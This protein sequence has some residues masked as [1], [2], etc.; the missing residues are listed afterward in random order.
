MSVENDLKLLLGALS[1]SAHKHRD[2]RRK[3]V[4]ASPY[5][6]HPI[7]VA[8]VLC[9]EGDVA[10]VAVICAALLHD[11]IEDTETLRDELVQE[12]GASITAIVEEVTDDKT[13]DKDVRKRLQI[14]HAV[15]ASRQAK[16]VKLAD[17]ICN[18]RDISSSPPAGWGTHRKQ[19]YFD[20]ANEVINEV[21]GVHPGLEA[22]FDIEYRKKPSSAAS[23][24]TA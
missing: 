22:L 16:L 17:K 19:A 13:L 12:F 21:R 3:D 18:L 9:N 6:N 5:I 14:E 4:D 11:T 10:E 7:S 1:F 8:N 2:Q 24:D 23:T 15:H 20:W